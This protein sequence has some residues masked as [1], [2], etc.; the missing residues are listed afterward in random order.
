LR[1]GKTATFVL[2][3]LLFGCRTAPVPPEVLEAD[4]QEQDL[5]RAGASVFAGQEHAAY[6]ESLK[7][8]RRT[9]ERESLKLG[10]LRDYGRIRADFASVIIEGNALRSAVQ[11]R[12]AR[13]SS[14]LAASA[15][16]VRRRLRTLDELTLSLVERG[17]G[18]QRL[19]RASLI[20]GEAEALA[21][22]YKF[23]VAAQRL[24]TASD[25]AEEAERAVIS[26]ISRYLDPAQ[27]KAW[28]EAAAAT[29]AESKRRNSTVIIVSKLERRLSVYRNGQRYRTYEVGLGFNGLADKRFAGDNATPEGRYTIVRKIPSHLYH[30]GLLIDYPNDED[31]RWFAREKARGA[32]P[33][34]ASI[35]GNVEIHGGGQDSLTRGCISLDNAMMDELYALVNIGTPVTIIGTM[36]PENFVIRAIRDQ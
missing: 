32:I 4:L 14:A 3:V 36:E 20:L 7:S 28:R 18:R 5:R 26:H 10:W 29:I 13:E 2:A 30:K 1:T 19:A 11:A 9:L 8:A 17:V 35:G 24:Q 6:L 23:D 22:A 25:L 16:A 27:V 31:R 15:A 12:I 33:R 34:G 21:A